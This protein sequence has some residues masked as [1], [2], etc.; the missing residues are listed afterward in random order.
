M[1]VIHSALRWG[2]VLS[3]AASGCLGQDIPRSS[4]EAKHELVAL[5]NHWLEVEGDP[6]ALDSILASDFLHVVPAGIITK[7]EQIEFMRKH[8]SPVQ[9]SPKKYFENMHV[10]VYGNVGVVNGVVVES[11]AGAIKK[12]LFTDVFVYRAGKWQAINAQELPA[13]KEQP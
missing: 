3:I 10:R 8:P 7:S 1:R 4:E 13:A 11:E 2:A 6:S 9:S 12:T 5:E